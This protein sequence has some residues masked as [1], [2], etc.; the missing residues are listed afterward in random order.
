MLDAITV[1]PGDKPRLAKRDAADTLGLDKDE[2]AR[3]LVALIAER[4]AKGK[5]K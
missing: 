1:T 5:P 4:L 2:V 3:R